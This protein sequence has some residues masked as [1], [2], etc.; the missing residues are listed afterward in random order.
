MVATIRDSVKRKKMT[1]YRHAGTKGE[2]YSFYSEVSFTPRSCLP[3]EWIPGTDWAGDC[4]GLSARLDTEIKSKAV[5][6]H[7]TQALEG[8]GD[9][10]ATYS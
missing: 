3:R 4:V 10:D 8:R 9:I 5:P 6:Q 1:G 7:A 2:R